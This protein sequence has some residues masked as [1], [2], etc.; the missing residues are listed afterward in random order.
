MGPGPRQLQLKMKLDRETKGAVRYRELD[1]GGEVKQTNYY[2][3]TLYMRKTSF[4]SGNW[5]KDL[6][7]Q[8]NYEETA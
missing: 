4:P 8:V 1:L 7:V 3:G 5:P 2:I 6:T